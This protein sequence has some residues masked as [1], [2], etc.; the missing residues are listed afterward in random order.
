M[1]TKEAAKALDE[2][3]CLLYEAGL[4]PADVAKLGHALLG[5]GLSQM[6]EEG[7][8]FAVANLPRSI[9]NAIEQYKANEARPVVLN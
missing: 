7:R 8:T 6:E 4:T 9:D 5:W 1:M 3:L 2:V